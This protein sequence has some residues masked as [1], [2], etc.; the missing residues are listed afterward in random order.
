MKDLKENGE[1]KMKAE[2]ENDNPDATIK[3]KS[4]NLTPPLLSIC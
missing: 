3:N 1:E 4:Q 2:K